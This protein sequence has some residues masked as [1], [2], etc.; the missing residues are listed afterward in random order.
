MGGVPVK[1][2]MP[3]HRNSDLRHRNRQWETMP[4]T[5]QISSMTLAHIGTSFPGSFP[6]RPMDRAGLSPRHHHSN[7]QS[8]SP[9]AFSHRDYDFYAGISSVRPCSFL[10]VS[11]CS[12]RYSRT[13]CRNHAGPLGGGSWDVLLRCLVVR[14]TYPYPPVVINCLGS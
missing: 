10:A 3:K 11:H 1:A 7:R 9:T 12:S 14:L 4:S 8:R 5:P 2:W 13:G 6:G